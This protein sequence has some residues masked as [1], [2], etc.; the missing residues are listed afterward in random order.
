MCARVTWV[1]AAARARA[2]P[3]AARAELRPHA[4]ARL[5]APNRARPTALARGCALCVNA[6]ATAPDRATPAPARTHAHRGREG[7]P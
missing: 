5:P 1:R 2:L 7:R 6:A 3:A 4:C